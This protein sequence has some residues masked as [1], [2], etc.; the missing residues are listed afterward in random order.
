[1]LHTIVSVEWGDI[2][3]QGL[4]VTQEFMDFVRFIYKDIFPGGYLIPKETVH[5]F[6]RKANFEVERTHSLRLHYA[7]TLD[8][9]A[10]NLAAN[11]Q[12]AIEMR[13]QQEYDRYMH[14]LE[15]CAKYFRSGHC[16]ICQFTCV[17]VSG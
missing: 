2:R 12:A 4:E 17:P 9:W 7:K 6:A 10:A 1:M 3:A 16:D 11:R 14:Y 13:S 8:I 5:K 15:G